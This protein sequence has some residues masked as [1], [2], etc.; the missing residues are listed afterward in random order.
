MLTHERLK[1]ILSYDPETGIFRWKLKISK[2]NNIGDIAG[3]LGIKGYIKICIAS[4]YYRANRLAWFY[5]TG[6]WP[7]NIVDHKNRIRNDDRWINIRDFTHKENSSNSSR[8]RNDRN[9]SALVQSFL[10]FSC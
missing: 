6:E 10:A 8:H 5:M 2:K 7:K 9:T 4:K 3:S 1:E